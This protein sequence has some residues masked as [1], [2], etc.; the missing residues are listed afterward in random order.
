MSYFLIASATV[1]LALSLV[2]CGSPRLQ[3]SVRANPIYFSQ[4]GDVIHFTYTI[5]N[6]G[7]MGTSFVPEMSHVV[8]L[9]CDDYFLDGKESITCTGAYTATQADVQAGSIH[10]TITVNYDHDIT[11]AST[12]ITL[13]QLPALQLSVAAN[14]TSFAQAGQN[15]TFTY[16]VENIGNVSLSQ[17]VT[18]Q[19]SRGAASP[20][21]SAPGW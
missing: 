11:S 9:D 19:D 18:I 17:R 12:E 16:T 3:V 10:H 1:L 4:A 2:G 6:A 14:P 8:H 13:N 15:I 21:P 7:R 5:Y 20:M